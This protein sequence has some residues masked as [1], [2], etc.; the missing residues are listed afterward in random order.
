[1][2]FHFGYS[3]GIAVGWRRRDRLPER[4]LKHKQAVDSR[5]RLDDGTQ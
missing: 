4:R 5:A 3:V 1:M 2:T